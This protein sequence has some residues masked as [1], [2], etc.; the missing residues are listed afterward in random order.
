M[1]SD[2]VQR[3]ITSAPIDYSYGSRDTR[4]RH[5]Y[6]GVGASRLLSSPPRR[7]PSPQ[8]DHRTRQIPR[9]RSSPRSCSPHRHPDHGRIPHAAP[10]GSR[11]AGGSEGIYAPGPQG[12]RGLQQA[13]GRM[14]PVESR[15]PSRSAA[16]TGEA[17]RFRNFGDSSPNSATAPAPNLPPINSGGLASLRV[18]TLFELHSAPDIAGPEAAAA[19][20]GPSKAAPSKG[21][22]LC[23]VHLTLQPQSLGR[24]LQQL[25]PSSSLAPH[26][27]Q[28][29][30]YCGR[31]N[32]QVLARLALGAPRMRNSCRACAHYASQILARLA[33]RKR[34][35]G[36]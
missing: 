5:D 7:T 33:L 18:S 11:S 2:L 21:S 13:A 1:D 12:Q 29:T 20:E 31:G 17:C 35:P 16:L 8:R 22:A 15:R 26:L 19:N 30:R 34:T 10:T 25:A 14:Y 27:Q 9:G 36:A 24:G 3:S 4:A 28:L 6:S 23:P 32:P